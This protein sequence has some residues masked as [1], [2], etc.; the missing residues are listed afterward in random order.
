MMSLKVEVDVER[1]KHNTSRGI[2]P[3]N[4]VDS[5]DKFY[6]GKTRPI[7]TREDGPMGSYRV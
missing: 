7:P 4:P 6:S 1:R 3:C 2:D 5:M